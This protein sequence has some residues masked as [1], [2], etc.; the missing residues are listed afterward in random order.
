ML[1]AYAR[2]YED[3][4]IKSVNDNIFDV[5]E[6]NAV[7]DEK[8]GGVFNCIDVFDKTD[9]VI[10]F[11]NLK[12]KKTKPN[13]LKGFFCENIRAF[14]LV[15][16]SF[17]SRKSFIVNSLNNSV[18]AY[19]DIQFASNIPK[20]TSIFFYLESVMFD[21]SSIGQS[22]LVISI[23]N[24]GKNLINEKLFLKN[25]NNSDLIIVSE[26]S[27]NYIHQKIKKNN[28]VNFLSTSPESYKLFL[29]NGKCYEFPNPYFLGGRKFNSSVGLGDRFATIL[30]KKLDNEKFD[31]IPSKKSIWR[32][33][34]NQ[35]SMQLADFLNNNDR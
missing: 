12:Q 13:L 26:E 4:I 10:T 25:S 24:G 27:L 14:I 32:S 21:I 16:K 35:T 2:L 8:M 17:K 31:L 22:G 18:V 11:G 3:T 28:K 20:G 19:R 29:A 7:V 15:D 30:A 33:L 1:I 5:N 6:T 9:I 23:F 34:L